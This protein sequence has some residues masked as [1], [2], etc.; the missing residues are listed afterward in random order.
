MH[1]MFMSAHNA[2]RTYFIDRGER[3]AIFGDASPQPTTVNNG[4]KS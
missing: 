4:V 2:H 3:K 1:C